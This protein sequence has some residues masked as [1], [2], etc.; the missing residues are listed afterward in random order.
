VRARGIEVVD[1]RDH[2]DDLGDAI[3]EMT[4]GRGPDSV[5]D[6]MSLPRGAPIA[7]CQVPGRAAGAADS[8]TLPGGTGTPDPELGVQ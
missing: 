8:G 6:A 7:C 4:D 2:E 5:L 1:L 3:R